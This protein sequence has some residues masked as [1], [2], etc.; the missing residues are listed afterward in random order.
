MLSVS[1]RTKILHGLRAVACLGLKHGRV[2]VLVDAYK[3]EQR[4]NISAAE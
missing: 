2:K 4:S 1:N 3:G